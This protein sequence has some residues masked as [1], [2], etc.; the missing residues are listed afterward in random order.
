MA[1]SN[2]HQR[3][4]YRS[5]S[6][7]QTFYLYISYSTAEIY[8]RESV[9]WKRKWK[10]QRRIEVEPSSKGQKI[11]VLAVC[12]DLQKEQEPPS[13]GNFLQIFVLFLPQPHRVRE[14][15][16]QQS[17]MKFRRSHVQAFMG[18]VCTLCMVITMNFR[19]NILQVLND[20]C[21]RFI[22]LSFTSDSEL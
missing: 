21:N 13:A 16:F 4:N 6:T 15:C 10:N 5:P 17:E 8:C 14:I 18:V 19:E 2:I 3:M 20:L 1:P 11:L 22:L 7:L 9:G 12:S